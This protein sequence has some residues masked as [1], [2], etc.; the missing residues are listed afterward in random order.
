MGS[1][2]NFVFDFENDSP[3]EMKHWLFLESVRLEQDRIDIDEQYKQLERDKKEFE[4]EK[5]EQAILLE[6]RRKKLDR[7]KELFEKQWRIVERELKRI[8]KDNERLENDR[9]Y[10]E[11]EKMNFRKLIKEGHEKKAEN[12][13]NITCDID[14]FAGTTGLV[15]VRKRYKELLKIFHP[16][17]I[18][19]DNTII[20]LINKAYEEQKKR[21]AN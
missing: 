9:A 13:V 10:L 2:V 18:N 5:K 15:G 19:G 14:F 3:E 20:Q 4:K 1:E 16:D 17:N 7:E 8:A 21:Y 11:R 6:T 12:V